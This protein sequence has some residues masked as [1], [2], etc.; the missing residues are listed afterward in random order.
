M[1]AIREEWEIRW[2]RDRKH[3][4]KIP[5]ALGSWRGSLVQG[6]NRMLPGSGAGPTAGGHGRNR[7]WKRRAS[8]PGFKARR[9]GEV[10]GRKSVPEEAPWEFRSLQ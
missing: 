9:F 5:I 7:E 2:S 10:P 6:K 1:S 4:F 3:L 8:Q